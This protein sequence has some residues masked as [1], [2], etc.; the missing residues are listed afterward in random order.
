M[1]IEQVNN[2][3]GSIELSQGLAHLIEL[4]DIEHSKKA[5][6]CFFSAVEKHNMDATFWLGYCHENGIGVVKNIAQAIKWYKVS[7]LHED[8]DSQ[9]RLGLCYL[10]GIGVEKDIDK[11]VEFFC[12]AVENGNAEA[13]EHLNQLKRKGYFDED[14]FEEII[15]LYRDDAIQLRYFPENEDDEDDDDLCLEPATEESVKWLSIAA[16]KDEPSALC[17]LALCYLN[18]DGVEKNVDKA[19]EL[20]K[21]ASAK[22]DIIAHNNLGYFY[23]KGFGA[24]KDEKKAVHHYKLAANEGGVDANYNLYRCYCDGIGVDKNL[25]KSY[26]HIMLAYQL[27]NKKKYHQELCEL[28]DQMDTQQVMTANKEAVKQYIVISE[29]L[30]RS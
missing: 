22:E 17:D 2:D 6:Q 7:A 5:Y 16:E 30:S 28:K 4:P 9:N 20:L 3:G 8:S 23:E 18:G 14:D 21:K 12:R 27:S 13:E 26:I 29:K 1:K 25:V 10:N 15:D 11:A 19:Y 24:A